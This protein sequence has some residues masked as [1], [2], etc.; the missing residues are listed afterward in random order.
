MVEQ[1]AEILGELRGLGTKIGQM[2]GALELVL[3]ERGRVIAERLSRLQNQASRSDPEQIRA[4]IEAELG[5]PLA[6]LFADFE[7][8]PSAS[9][10]IGQVHRARLHDGQEVAVKVQHP[11]VEE[12]LREDLEGVGNVEWLVRRVAPY[13]GSEAVGA[14]IRAI[15]LAELDYKAEAVAQA[16]AA[17]HYV[18]DPDIFVP[19]PIRSHSSARVLCTPL[20]RGQGLRDPLPVDA[21]DRAGAALWR[22]YQ[23]GAVEL[24]AWVADPHPGNFLIS[25]EGR[26]SFLDFGCLEPVPDLNMLGQFLRAAKAGNGDEVD[27]AGE[28]LFGAQG[29]AGRLLLRLTVAPAAVLPG[30]LF[31]SPALLKEL[32][33]VMPVAKEEAIRRG[34]PLSPTLPLYYK[35]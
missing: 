20:L 15:F 8:E 9:A 34:L 11:G 12:A 28:A 1:A 5:A 16:R 10:S 3:P 29:P 6:E 32:A 18:G 35:I 25:P 19:A 33:R 21:R 13:G 2:G 4:R 24:G 23:E 17:A 26:V 7:A 30:A 22:F 31:V 27:R 14:H